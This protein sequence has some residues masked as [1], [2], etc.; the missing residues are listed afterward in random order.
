MSINPNGAA[1][2]PEHVST[3]DDAGWESLKNFRRQPTPEETAQAV[4]YAKRLYTNVRMTQGDFREA[5][6]KNGEMSQKT[7][8]FWENDVADDCKRAEGEIDKY[9]LR[10]SQAAEAKDEMLSLNTNPSETIEAQAAR[11]Y[12]VRDKALRQAIES[13]DMPAENK[14]QELAFMN[15]FLASVMKHLS[16]KYMTAEEVIERGSELSDR[17]RTKAHNDVIKH[18]NGLNDL[19]RKHGTRPFT[20]RNFWPSDLCDSDR[21]TP[22]I[23]N[24]MKKDRKIVEAYYTMAFSEAVR[25]RELS[26]RPASKFLWDRYSHREE[27]PED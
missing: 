11:F 10:L 15:D 7:F 14:R 8:E 9:D 20:A 2:S 21:Q 3:D 26:Q 18:L 22:A 6:A 12:Y 24:V 23:T 27:E 17:E 19:A 25:Q 1:S 13:S 4:S 16:F 5:L